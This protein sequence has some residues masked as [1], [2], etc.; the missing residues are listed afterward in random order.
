MTDVDASQVGGTVGASQPSGV[1]GA[2]QP[3]GTVGA[4]LAKPQADLWTPAQLGDDLALWLDWQ[5]SPFDLRTDGGTD[6]VERWGDLSGNGNDATQSAGSQQPVL[7][8][9]LMFDGTDDL[10]TVSRTT[11]QADQGLSI[12]AVYT[13]PGGHNAGVVGRWGSTRECVILGQ[14]FQSDDVD[15]TSKDGSGTQTNTSSASHQDGTP[16]I[17]YANWGDV[18]SVQIDGGTVV[19]D[20]IQGVQGGD[21]LLKIGGYGTIDTL[22]EM[23][24]NVIIGVTTALSSAKRDKTVGWAAH[25]FDLTDKLPADHPYKSAAPRV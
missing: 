5:D 20:S 24:L 23:N 10:L 25:K 9:G 2:S 21:S 15:L 14:G 1:V 16:H 11:L 3:S 7:D 18:Q 22:I 12:L 8:G 13:S 4:R 17:V 6:Y 19:S